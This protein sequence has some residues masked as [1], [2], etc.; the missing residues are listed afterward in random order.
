MLDAQDDTSARLNNLTLEDHSGKVDVLDTGCLSVSGLFI[1]IATAL[2]NLLTTDTYAIV[3]S[4][5][6]AVGL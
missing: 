4:D 5:L 1:T 3:R 2:F 6:A